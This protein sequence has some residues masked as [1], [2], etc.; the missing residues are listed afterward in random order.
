MSS[1]FVLLA[2]NIVDDA[3]SK[4]VLLSG[5]MCILYLLAVEAVSV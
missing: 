4:A 3:S 2:V 1:M 5:C